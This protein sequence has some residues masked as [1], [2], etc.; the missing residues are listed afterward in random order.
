MSSC[1]NDNLIIFAVT[2]VSTH[3]NRHIKI[4]VFGAHQESSLGQTWSKLLKISE[5]I[6]FDIKPWKMLFC[7]DF[8]LVW[9]L[10]N[11][12]LTMGILVI[13]AG[14]GTLSVLLFEW[15][16]PWHYI[17]SCDP[18]RENEFFFGFLGSSMLIKGE[19]NMVSTV[20]F[21]EE[22]ECPSW[23]ANIVPVKKM[24]S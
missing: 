23:L 15:V 13:L 22:I 10:V 1:W 3:F 9:P 20:G 11:P 21:I 2:L 18:K 5:E 12:R 17:C 6:R 24:G 4:W 14:K 16:A 7:E 8:D 19:K